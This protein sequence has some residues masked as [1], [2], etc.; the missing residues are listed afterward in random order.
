MSHAQFIALAALACAALLAWGFRHLPGARWQFLACVPLA[1]EAP[2]HWRGLNLTWYGLLSANAQALAAAWLMLLAAT[3]GVPW[4]AVGALLAA[5][6]AL[7]LSGSRW[8]ARLVE[9]KAH[10]FTVGGATFLGMLLAPGMFWLANQGLAWAGGAG[11]PLLCWCAAL[12]VAYAL[13]EGLGRLA[14]ISFGCCYG[15]PLEDCPPWLGRLFARANFVFRGEHKKIAYASGLE[16]RRVVPVQA[17]T[18]VIHTGAALAGTY[19]FLGG[20]F[21]A[22]LLTAG[23]TTQLW[24]VASEFLRADFRGG[25]RLSAYQWM[26]L[27]TA[28]WL[29][30][31][32]WLLPGGGQAPPDLARGLATLWAAGPLVLLQGTW[33]AA[34]LYYG[35][36]RVT[37]S[38]LSFSVLRHLI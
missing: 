4:T 28:A 1:E 17:L 30:G 25:G 37:A 15:R 11:A 8:L 29:G 9:K 3:L 24:R 6:C 31:L 35:R 2:G 13:G 14:C 20:H 26:A 19:L 18:A 21:A 27:A 5:L 23:L 12:A 38:R 32:A 33:L 22:S 16:G 10:T 34:F 36:S 7:C